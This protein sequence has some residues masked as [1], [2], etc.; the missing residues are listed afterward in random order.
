MNEYDKN[1]DGLL[2]RQ[3]MTA[4]LVPDIGTTAKEE[5]AHLFNEAD[6]DKVTN[7][8]QLVKNCFAEKADFR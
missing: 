6:K 8:V 3:E 1:K 2:D 7:I 5:V 4:W